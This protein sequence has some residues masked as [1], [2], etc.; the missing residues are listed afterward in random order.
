ML[1]VRRTCHEIAVASCLSFH[2]PSV[3][4]QRLHSPAMRPLPRLEGERKSGAIR[5]TYFAPRPTRRRAGRRGGGAAASEALP[6]GRDRDGG[7]RDRHLCAAPVP[8]CHRGDGGQG[9]QAGAVRRSRAAAHGKRRLTAGI[10]SV[11]PGNRTGR[12]APVTSRLQA[13]KVCV[14]RLLSRVREEA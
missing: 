13:G 9:P 2:P 12:S 10:R 5:D 7:S 14:C 1:V 8:D 6:L 11:R 4:R 3:L